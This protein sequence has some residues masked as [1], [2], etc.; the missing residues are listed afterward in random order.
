[1]KLAFLAAAAACCLLVVEAVPAG[2]VTNTGDNV[3]DV[4]QAMNRDYGDGTGARHANGGV[5]GGNEVKSRA[6]ILDADKAYAESNAKVNAM[7]KLEAQNG[8]AN[9]VK[10]ATRRREVRCRI[11]M[12]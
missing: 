12:M 6:A 8:M 10:E 3:N 9:S 2:K 4:H 5:K 7:E 1:M 11:L